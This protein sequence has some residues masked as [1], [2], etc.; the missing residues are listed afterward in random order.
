MNF[1]IVFYILQILNQFLL[2]KHARWLI[3][4]TNVKLKSEYRPGKVN[5]STDA[6]LHK[7]NMMGT[8]PGSE[9]VGIPAQDLKETAPKLF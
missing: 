2:G 8:P 5:N 1:V 4:L 3:T 7:P 9:Q 6:L